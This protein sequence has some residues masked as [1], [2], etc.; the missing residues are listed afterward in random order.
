MAR[1]QI[2]KKGDPVLRREAKPVREVNKNIKTLMAN[3]A[4]T[5]YHANGVGLAAPQVGISK[6]V[7]VVD[8]GDGLLSLANP[9]IVNFE[10][11]QNGPEGCLSVPGVVGNVV[12]ADKIV[13]TALNENGDEVIINAEGFKARALQHE[14]D[15]LNGVL[16]VDKATEIETEQRV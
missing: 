14:L 3:M 6:R 10:G 15:H 1:Y 12:R 7:I 5:M 16:F 8:I 2:L 9:V 11:K 13:M 4:E